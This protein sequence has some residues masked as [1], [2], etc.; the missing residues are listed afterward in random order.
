LLTVRVLV[1]LALACPAVLRQAWSARPQE[2]QVPAPEASLANILKATGDYCEIVKSMALFFVCQERILDQENFFTRGRA[3]DRTSPDALMISRSKKRRFV[4]DYQVIKKADNFEEKRTLLEEDGQKRHQENANLATLNVSAR[5]LVFGPVGFLSRYW[6][7]F[8]VYEIQGEEVVED[9]TAVIIKAVPNEKRAENN[10]VGRVWVD[11]LTFQ[12]LRIEL[13]PPYAQDLA[14]SF[15]GSGP[16]GTKYRRHF[17]W[18]VDYGVEKNGVRFPSR[19]AIREELVSD[20]GYKAL[21]CE[22]LFEFT[23]YKFFTVEVEIK[24]RR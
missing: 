15:D 22:V 18:T 10:N 12:I 19:Q 11:A 3:A 6:Q 9:K 5:N 23:D 16:V 1:L 2:A 13:E 4:Y 17:T 8:F 14:V 24:S 20:T 21:K 7:K